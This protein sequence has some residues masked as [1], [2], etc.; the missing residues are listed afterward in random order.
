MPDRDPATN[1]DAISL[2]AAVRARYA[3]AA[4]ALTTTHP[5]SA[6]SALPVLDQALVRNLIPLCESRESE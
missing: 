1:A 3:A 4:S 2:R 5:T 6:E